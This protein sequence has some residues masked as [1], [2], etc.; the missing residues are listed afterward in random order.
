MVPEMSSHAP[1]KVDF[2]HFWTLKK[3]GFQICL[4]FFQIPCIYR[5]YRVDFCW[6]AWNFRTSSF[7]SSSLDVSL[8]GDAHVES[9]KTPV[10]ST[11]QPLRRPYPLGRNALHP[12][13]RPL[14]L[15]S[16]DPSGARSSPLG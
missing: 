1:Q 10:D 9:S 15:G 3:V 6:G 13:L 4:D 7:E 16:A 14:N 12:S 11:R 5:V 8:D 2:G